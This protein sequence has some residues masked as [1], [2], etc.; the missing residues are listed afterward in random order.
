MRPN[1]TIAHA[2][3]KLTG[4][5]QLCRVGDSPSNDVVFGK[6]AGVKTALLD[7]GRR[8]TEGG[9]T[10]DPDITV[11]HMAQLAALIWRDFTV[12]SPLTDPALHAKREAPTPSGAAAAAAVAGDAAALEGMPVEALSAADATGQTPMIWAADGG[13]LPSVEVLLRK[14]VAVDARGFLGATA[15]SRAARRGFD[16]VLAALLAHGAD[17]EIPN[18]KLQFPMHFASFKRNP[19]AVR[20]LLEHGASPLVLDRKGRT[21]AEDTSDDAIRAE[22]R[23]AQRIYVEQALS[24]ASA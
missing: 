17:A 22:I 4:T 6:A 20:V 21:P 12:T 1:G 3:A 5:L 19:S 11:E 16:D 8:L 14:G 10:N 23:V 9:A 13:S 15:V 24:G 7:T 18:V 2:G